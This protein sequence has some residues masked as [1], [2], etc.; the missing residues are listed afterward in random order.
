MR[1]DYRTLG[2]P[3]M[4]KLGGV[5]QYIKESALPET[6]VELV[7]LRTSQINGC[8]YCIEQHTKQLVRLGIELKKMMLVSAWKEAGALF[9]EQERAA[10]QWAESITQLQG[11]NPSDSAFEEIRRH[12]N[13]KELFDLTLAIS[14]M[15]S[16]NRIAITFRRPPD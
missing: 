2:S 3:A 15:N 6:L 11:D 13:D 9:S 7:Y 12:F 1:L 16:Y 10:L 8:A 5:Y 4:Q 14:L